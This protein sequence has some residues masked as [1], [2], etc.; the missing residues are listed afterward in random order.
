M[1]RS[2]D[3]HYSKLH[4]VV[5]NYGGIA[6]QSITYTSTFRSIR[7]ELW[8]FGRVGSYYDPVRSMFLR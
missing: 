5:L 7:S 1:I 4:L 2:F 8:S 3:F 6:E